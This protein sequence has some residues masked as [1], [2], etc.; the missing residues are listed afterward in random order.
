MKAMIEKKGQMIEKTLWEV[1]HENN[2][3]EERIDDRE[4]IMGRIS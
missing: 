3:R 1:Y 2:D 4:D